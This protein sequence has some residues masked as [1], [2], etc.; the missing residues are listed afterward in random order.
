MRHLYPA[1][2]LVNNDLNTFIKYNW[3][4]IKMMLHNLQRVIWIFACEYQESIYFCIYIKPNAFNS[5]IQISK[6]QNNI[7]LYS[8][9][10][11]GQI[12][13]ADL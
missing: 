9:F 2:V 11:L 8:W 13:T 3:N 10:F 12:C 4:Q 7:I 5:D 6:Y 1:A